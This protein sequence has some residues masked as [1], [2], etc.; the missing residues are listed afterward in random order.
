MLKTT[1]YCK[2]SWKKLL[3]WCRVF[4]V[5]NAA[6]AYFQLGHGTFI[7]P[8]A[9]LAPYGAPTGRNSYFRECA[10][11]VEKVYS[12]PSWSRHMKKHQGVFLHCPMCDYKNPFSDKLRKH[13]WRK[14]KIH[15]EIY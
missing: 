1:V 3:M 6:P 2:L 5:V 11:C 4:L 8:A 10:I 9:R 12:Q 15:Y 13:M 14:R 7:M